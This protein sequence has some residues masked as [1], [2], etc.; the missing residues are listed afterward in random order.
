MP[1]VSHKVAV[2]SL[3]IPVGG[4]HVGLVLQ[5][6]LDD[7]QVALEGHVDGGVVQRGAVEVIPDVRVDAPQQEI[8]GEQGV[9]ELGGQVQG[10]LTELTPAVDV[11]SGEYQYLDHVAVAL[12]HGVLHGSQTLVVLHPHVGPGDHQHLDDRVTPALDCEEERS[13]ALVVHQVHRL[14]GT[15]DEENLQN[16]EITNAH[17]YV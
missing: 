15:G 1:G 13:V 14:F 7:A 2:G 11:G 6:Y 12:V 10:G 5:E 3:S 8:L 4:V 16:V 9:V 17:C